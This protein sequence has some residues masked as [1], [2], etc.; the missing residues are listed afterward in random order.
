MSSRLILQ[1]NVE[2][3]PNKKRRGLAG[4]IVSTALS[5][6]LIGTAVGLTVYR[7]WRDRG[8]EPEP[9]TLPPPP[10]YQQGE[11]RPTE[12]PQPVKVNKSRSRSPSV[13]EV[14]SPRPSQPHMTPRSAKRVKQLTTQKRTATYQRRP[15]RARGYGLGHASTP[16]T[17]SASAGFSPRPEFDFN[18][19]A[20]EESSGGGGGYEDQM[21]WIGDKLAMLIEQGKRA[22][23][24]EVVVMSDAKEDEV[25]DGT[26][27]WV[28]EDEDELSTRGRYGSPASSIR[29]G[30]RGRRPRSIVPPPPPSS[31]S[32]SH[33]YGSAL[34]SA[35]L[36]YTTS[37][38][39]SRQYGSV[40]SSHSRGMSHESALVG[41]GVS[42]P[43]RSSRSLYGNSSFA[44]SS[45]VSLAT[46]HREDTTAWESPEMR[47][48][49]ERAR[50]RF[51]MR[52]E[53]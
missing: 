29:S 36:D 31:S 14:S 32:T 18:S 30:K 21:D 52:R 1:F 19:G 11:W 27:D 49:M 16:S 53:G 40:G 50:A 13:H 42:T 25:D 45:S 39:Q 51:G 37:P 15:A 7:L 10:P 6:A 9:M 3:P 2:M 22:L 26:G 5:A 44:N 28:E 35:P 17:A 46:A 48:S 41:L 4:S 43:S 34:G 33:L 38:Y 20:Q 47:E 24:T 12:Q 8:K 23:N